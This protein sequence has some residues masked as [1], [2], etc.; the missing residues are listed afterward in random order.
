MQDRD[1]K[2][3][4]DKEEAGKI[5]VQSPF[6][7]WLDNFWY[8]NKWIVIIAGIFLFAIVV[9]VVQCAGRDVSDAYV[10][11]AGGVNLTDKDKEVLEEILND[12]SEDA[13]KEEPLDVGV[14]GYTYYSE[15]ELRALYTDGENGFD[16]EGFNRAKQHNR[17]RFNNMRDYVVTGECSIW[18]VSE[19]VYAELD[20]HE[21]LAVPLKSSLKTIPEAAYDDCA[22]RLSETAF[23]RYYKEQLSFLPAD[24]LIV[25]TNPNTV[26]GASSDEEHYEKVKAIYRAIVNFEIKE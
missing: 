15:E 23:Y 19:A 9:C 26:W 4:A 7:K 3:H 17:E 5:V 22:I 14:L 25:L 11:F 10:A 18:F 21:Q 13:A 1:P 20:M 16:N 12:I 2:S 8:H 6:I 24:T